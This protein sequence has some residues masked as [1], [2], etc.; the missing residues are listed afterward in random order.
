MPSSIPSAWQQRGHFQFFQQG[1]GG[2]IQACTMAFAGN[3]LPGFKRDQNARRGASRPWRSS[4]TRLLSSRLASVS[5]QGA[6]PLTR[7]F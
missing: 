4:A 6:R 1:I 7:C 5:A 2:Q 3:V